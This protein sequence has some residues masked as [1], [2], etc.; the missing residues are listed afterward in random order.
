MSQRFL[1][2]FRPA[3]EAEYPTPPGRLFGDGR[4]GIGQDDLLDF[5]AH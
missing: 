2:Y 5:V 3:P 4:R 1:R